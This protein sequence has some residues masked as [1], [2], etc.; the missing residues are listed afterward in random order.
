MTLQERETYSEMLALL[1]ECLVNG[2]E[3]MLSLWAW[4]QATQIH[5]EQAL[6]EGQAFTHTWRLKPRQLAPGEQLQPGHRI[7]VYP[8]TEDSSSLLSDKELKSLLQEA[9][10]SEEYLLSEEVVHCWE[11]EGENTTVTITPAMHQRFLETVRQAQEE[12]MKNQ[13]EDNE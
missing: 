1:E 7:K 12:R 5:L 8:P 4:F 9:F 13:K 6:K 11:K 3:N 2:K 10:A